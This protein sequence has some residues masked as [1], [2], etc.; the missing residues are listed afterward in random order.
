MDNFKKDLENLIN[1]HAI[2][3]KWDMPDYIMAEFICNLINSVSIPMRANLDWH[4]VDSVCH[5]CPERN[6]ELREEK[7]NVENNKG[8]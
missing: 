5:P 6:K 3:N 7:K 2:E 1:T 4:G 8:N